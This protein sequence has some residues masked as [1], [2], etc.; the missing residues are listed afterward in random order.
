MADS[1][2]KRYLNQ[3]NPPRNIHGISLLCVF[4][5]YVLTFVKVDE[6]QNTSVLTRPHPLIL[7]WSDIMRRSSWIW[8][9]CCLPWVCCFF[10]SGSRE[11]YLKKKKS[12]AQNW[13]LHVR[14]CS[15]HLHKK[16]AKTSQDQCLECHDI[17]Q[18]PQLTSWKSYQQY[19]LNSWICWGS[20]LLF[21]G[22]GW[23]SHL[24]F[25]PTLKWG[26][27]MIVFDFL[28]QWSSATSLE[29]MTQEKDC[30]SWL[31]KLT[32]MKNLSLKDPSF[33]SKLMGPCNRNWSWDE[34]II[35]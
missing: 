34:K 32:W 13:V 30:S 9:T 5:I 2:I 10:N 24:C 3:V 7:L 20:Q 22:G 31:M 1:F 28:L 12:T 4:V 23:W 16:G 35:V 17:Y 14:A 19:L 6:L 15:W 11:F 27:I 33:R 26:Y 25:Q 21:F 8:R 18:L 29:W